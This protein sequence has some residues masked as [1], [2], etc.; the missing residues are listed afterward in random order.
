MVCTSQQAIHKEMEYIRKTLQACNFPPWALNTLQHGFNHRHITHNGQNNYWQPTQQ[1]QQYLDQ[2]EKKKHLHSGTI[3]PLTWGKVQR[4]CNN[5]KIHAHF[6][7]SNIIKTLLM[8]PKDRD[9]KLQKSGVIYRYN[10]CLYI[11]CLE[12]YIRELGRTF[13]DRL[14]KHLRALCTIIVTL[15]DTP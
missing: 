12:E 4:T 14:K 15:Q 9:N 7:R 5:L 3:H 6:K 2:I 13:G 11:N 8:A 1:H 10:K